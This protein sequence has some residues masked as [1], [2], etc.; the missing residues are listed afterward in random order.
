VNQPTVFPLVAFGGQLRACRAWT[1]RLSTERLLKRLQRSLS[2]SCPPAFITQ[3]KKLL[4]VVMLGR[5]RK[6][7]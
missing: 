3:H 7:W 1:L 2:H 4:V 5:P 6:D